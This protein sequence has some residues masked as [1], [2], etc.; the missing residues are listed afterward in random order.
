[1]KPSIAILHYTSP[2]VIGGV[3][4]VMANHVRAMRR[5]GYPVAVIAGRGEGSALV[6]GAQFMRVSEMDSLAAPPPSTPDPASEL[7]EGRVP[8]G[9]EAQVAQIRAAL[10]PHLARFDVVIM[11]NIFSKHFNLALTA[12]LW[13]MLDDGEL[14]GCIAWG[15]DFSW[16][17]PSSRSAVFPRYPWDLLRR[18]RPDIT[19]VAVSAQRQHELA[20]LFGCPPEEIHVIYNGVE[21]QEQLGLSPQGAELAER[22]G[23]YD[24]APVLLMPVRVTRAKNI[25]LALEV[26][27]ALAR[28]DCRPKLVLTGPPDPH[29]PASMAYFDELRDRRRELAIESEMTFIFE[30][31]PDPSTPLFLDAAVVGDL[32]R[33][34]DMLFMPS[35]REGFGM[36]VLEAG[37]AGL[38]VACTAIPAAAELAAD[39]VLLFNP[40]DA[41]AE[42]ARR[43]LARLERD[44]V[45]RLRRRVRARYTWDA[46][47]KEDIAPLLARVS[48]PAR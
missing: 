16:T 8:A 27:A 39:D 32:Y 45:Y 35:H 21:P 15:H 9:F 4:A 40:D 42:I 13:R 37:L 34:S 23:L 18:R 48:A 10:K 14:P 12:A 17:S 25:E 33:L 19:Y 22:L 2:P 30:A 29:D 26:V 20:T 41:P 28:L 36:P 24:H 38:P 43:I 6:P 31:G 47:L 5:A 7:R 11:H 44:P 46:I 3:E 1:M